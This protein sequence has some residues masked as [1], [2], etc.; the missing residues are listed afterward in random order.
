M[1]LMTTLRKALAKKLS[2][3]GAPPVLF[4][5]LANIDFEM[6]QSDLARFGTEYVFT[7]A[8]QQHCYTVYDKH[9]FAQ[10]KTLYMS[11]GKQVVITAGD[12]N[13]LN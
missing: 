2:Q 9:T 1:K 6:R 7:N 3:K 4:V 12:I 11:G 5:P 13:T 8:N 10:Q